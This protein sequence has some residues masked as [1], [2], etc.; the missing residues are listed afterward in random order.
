MLRGDCRAYST[1]WWVG[2]LAFCVVP[3][4]ALAMGVGRYF[5]A[6]AE[7]QK[8]SDAAALAAAQEVNIPLYRDMGQIELM[9]SAYAVASGYAGLN[10]SYLTARGINTQITGI[11]VDQGS[12]TVSVSMSADASAL[13]PSVFHGIIVRAEGMAE[14]RLKNTP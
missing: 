3:L 9:P 4:F 7:I 11:R 2:F 1:L 6:R 13:F 8:A 12:R 5:Y 10:S 14:V